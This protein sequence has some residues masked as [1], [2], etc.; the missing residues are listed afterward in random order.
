MNY[1]EHKDL[2]EQ[3][4]IMKLMEKVYHYFP[5]NRMFASCEEFE[6]GIEFFVGES[7]HRD[8]NKPILYK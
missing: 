6:N 1:D 3:V 4:R 2:Q 7:Y 8:R 5:Y